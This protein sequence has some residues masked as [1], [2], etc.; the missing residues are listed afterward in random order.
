MAALDKYVVTYD[1]DKIEEYPRERHIEV[2]ERL[3]D[4][5]KDNTED[6]TDNNE[7]NRQYFAE[8]VAN[9]YAGQYG[10]YSQM[11]K[12]ILNFKV[13]ITDIEPLDK[14]AIRG[15]TYIVMQTEKDFLQGTT[16]IE[17]RGY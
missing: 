4:D 9:Y 12:N 8:M 11:S 6:F 3:K 17:L 5:T 10:I 16:K 2:Y 13:D 1:F 7:F 15:K 14:M